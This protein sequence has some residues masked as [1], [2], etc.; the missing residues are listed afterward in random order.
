MKLTEGC[1]A[2]P[3]GG[4]YGI[5]VVNKSMSTSENLNEESLILTSSLAPE[6]HSNN[7]IIIS[8]WHDHIQ[9]FILPSTI[10]RKSLHSSTVASSFSQA[11][12]PSSENFA[13]NRSKSASAV[14]RG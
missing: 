7:I 3:S 5:P 14:Y 11:L 6:Q 12:L 9:R 10:W 1:S 4:S 13:G 8:V 2:N